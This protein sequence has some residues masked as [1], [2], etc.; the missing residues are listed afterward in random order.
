VTTVNTRSAPATTTLSERYVHA[1]TRRLPLDQREDV[2]DELRAGID[3]RVESLLAGDPGLA[4][5]EA[6]RVALGELGDPAL[7]ADGY[8]GTRRQLIGPELYAGYVTVLKAVLVTVVPVVAVVIAVVEALSGSSFGAVV[9]E[10]VWTAM[11]LAVHIAFWVTVAFA[12]VERG[13]APDDVRDS[14]GAGWDPDK[15]PELPRTSGGPVS[16]LVASVVF[17]SLIGAV[18]VWQQVRPPVPA[19]G[20]RVPVLDP[21]LWSFWLPLVLVLLVV[22]IGFEVVKH[23]LGWSVR[24]ATVNT[25]LAAVF[26]APLVYLAATEQLLNPAATAAIQASWSEL[27]PSVAHTVVLVSA[28]VIAVWDSVDGWVKTRAV[29]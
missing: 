2:A 9:G 4:P 14:L 7:L 29:S 11:N 23:R 3:D 6:E 19:D 15:L 25:V 18:L 17:L 1:V 26:A 24:M 8:T 28:L 22:E 10:T 12:L 27:D 21:D 5:A 13:S 16:D 20:E